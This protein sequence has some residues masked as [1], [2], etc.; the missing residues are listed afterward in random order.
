ML[1]IKLKRN[2]RKKQPN[3]KIIINESL[4]KRDGKAFVELGFYNPFTKELSI[5][6]T[7]LYKYINY[8]AQPTKTV[9]YLIQKIIYNFL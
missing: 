1:K 2:G 4:T 6:K 7:L 8:G 5:N 9:R 3:Y